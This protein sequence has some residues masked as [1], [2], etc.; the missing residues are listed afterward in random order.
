MSLDDGPDVHGGTGESQGSGTSGTGRPRRTTSAPGATRS[1]RLWDAISVKAPDFGRR[2]RA[3]VAAFRQ[4]PD[5][6][7]TL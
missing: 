4:Q 6:V 5:G 1:S 2:Q 7:Y 3:A